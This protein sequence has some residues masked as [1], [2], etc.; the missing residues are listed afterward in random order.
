MSIN[1]NKDSKHIFFMNLALMQAYKNLGNT[2]KNPSVGCVIVSNGHLIGAG[3]TSI[4]GRPHAEENAMNFCQSKIKDSHIYITLEPCSHTGKTSP[5]VKKIINKKIKKVFFSL[6]DPDKRSYGKSIKQL[7]KKKIDVN[8][9]ILISEIY[10][11]YESYIKYKKNYLPHVTC[12][13]AASKDLFTVNRKEKWITNYFSRGRVHVMRSRHD[14]ILTSVKT[15]ID[16]NPLLNCRI[17][18]LEDRSPSRIIIDKNLNIPLNSKIVKTAHKHSTI[19]FFNKINTKKSTFLKKNKI[20]LIW[21]PTNDEGNFNLKD[22]TKKIKFLGFSRIFL[23]AGLNLTTNFL[24]EG[25]INDFYLFLS[26]RKLGNIGRN[27][28]KSN[29]KI[30]KKSKKFFKEKV[31]LLGDKLITYRIN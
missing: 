27:S 18:G 8:H 24:N 2:K 13:L 1:Q 22:L 30:L 28:F 25:L 5:C 20:Q 21:L 6:K 26:P 17:F 14:C 16:D 15:I 10:K 29:M 4:N 3:N 19:I 12:K 11:F 31:N 23:E 7:K 9:G